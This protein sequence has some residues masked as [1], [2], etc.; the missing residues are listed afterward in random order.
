MGLLDVV[1]FK[2]ALKTCAWCA[3]GCVAVFKVQGISVGVA[4]KLRGSLGA[5]RRR[6]ANRKRR[7][8]ELAALKKKLTT[9]GAKSINERVGSPSKRAQAVD[10][11]DDGEDA[12]DPND[13]IAA[14]ALD[15][16]AAALAAEGDPRAS[17]ELA[18]IAARVK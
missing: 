13:T 7:R 8:A 9:D 11:G 4:M 18:A 5:A 3:A 2:H 6:I 10:G 16:V 15:E 17:A 14:E 12:P 1:P